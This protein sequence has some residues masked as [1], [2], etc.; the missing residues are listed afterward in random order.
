MLTSLP[1]RARRID[2]GT[3]RVP[4]HKRQL[5]PYTSRFHVALMQS[6][7]ET[8]SR[9]EPSTLKNLLEHLAS[10]DHRPLHLAG[11]EFEGVLDA[12]RAN[13]FGR[14][15]EKRMMRVHQQYLVHLSLHALFL[16]GLP[17]VQIVAKFLG[18]YHAR[19]YYPEE[20]GSRL[21]DAISDDLLNL[22]A[23][24]ATER[25]SVRTQLKLL[26]LGMVAHQ[27]VLE[28]GYQVRWACRRRLFCKPNKY[29]PPIGW[30]TRE[31]WSRDVLIDFLDANPALN[32]A[33]KE[34][35]AQLRTLGWNRAVY[36]T[37][38]DRTE[39]IESLYRETGLPVWNMAN[40]I[41]APSWLLFNRQRCRSVDLVLKLGAYI[42]TG[43]DPER[44][45]CDV[46]AVDHVATGWPKRV[47]Q[48]GHLETL[49]E[50]LGF[51]TYPDWRTQRG[52][53]HCVVRDLPTV[54]SSGAVVEFC[55]L[56]LGLDCD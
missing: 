34:S 52:R 29:W 5:P 38:F 15:A 39:T 24:P 4:L 44:L 32:P 56:D 21:L 40:Y 13:R 37:G 47:E 26:L 42:S 54:F 31:R 10:A 49:S 22:E 16:E 27:W 1:T 25:D 45:F 41:N 9:T 18:Y 53:L 33:V 19:P 55:P 50:H 14:P 3:R 7:V 30:P 35:C 17:F 51:V 11:T 8:A 20:E 36:E 12:I 23:V 2:A 43:Y 48:V 6:M 28:L 46:S